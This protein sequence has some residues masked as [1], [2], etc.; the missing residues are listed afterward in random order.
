M[1]CACTA[2]ADAASPHNAIKMLFLILMRSPV[3][4]FGF[5]NSI[6][7]NAALRGKVII[8]NYSLSILSNVL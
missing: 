8:S 1:T 4:L 7:D 2:P 5:E 6:Y 3:E